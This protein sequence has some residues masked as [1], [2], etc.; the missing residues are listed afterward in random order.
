M[1]VMGKFHLMNIKSALNQRGKIYCNFCKTIP[2]RLID[3]DQFSWF[4]GK[5]FSS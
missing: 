1:V 2:R 5:I 4:L 3:I